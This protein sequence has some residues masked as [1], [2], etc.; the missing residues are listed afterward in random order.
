MN[1]EFSVGDAKLIHAKFSRFGD[2]IKN[3]KPLFE[4]LADDFLKVMTEQFASEGSHTSNN[5]TPLSKNYADWKNKNYPDRPIL[6]LNGNMRSSLTHKGDSNGIRDITENEMTLGS[7]DK[8]AVWHHYGTRSLPARKIIDMSSE[9]K[10][11]WVKNMHQWVVLQE[12]D[13]KI[14]SNT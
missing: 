12:R 14:G 8:K 6:V 10:T 9:D 2:S 7:K 4:L 1:L 11:R 3:W 13:A 5:W